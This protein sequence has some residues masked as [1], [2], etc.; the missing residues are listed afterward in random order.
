LVTFS[1]AVKKTYPSLPRFPTGIDPIAPFSLL[2]AHL[3]LYGP[4]LPLLNATQ[5]LFNSFRMSVNAI[6]TS[7][8]SIGRDSPYLLASDRTHALPRLG[9][10]R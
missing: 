4:G 1:N 8:S 10:G 6:T 9:W 2:H 7:A 3:Q 5:D